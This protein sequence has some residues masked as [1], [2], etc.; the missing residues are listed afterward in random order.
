MKLQTVY[1]IITVAVLFFK[2][3]RKR[4]GKSLNSD[5]PRIITL[6]RTERKLTQKQ[7]AAALGI[8]QALLSHYE[9][10]IRECGLDFLVKAA[11]L[12]GVSCDYLLGRTPYRTGAQI[13]LD[14]IPDIDADAKDKLVRGG[15]MA[16]VLN[17]RL[18]V[19]SLNLLYDLLRKL[20]SKALTNEASAYLMLAV[21][22]VFHRL[23]VAN[24]KNAKSF[25]SVDKN[26]ADC[27]VNS[28]MQIAE[29]RMSSV[30]SGKDV[31]KLEGLESVEELELSEDYMQQT[32]PQYF[33]SLLGLIHAAE[34]RLPK[35]DE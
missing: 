30:A 28:A 14:D 10:G 11:D 4:G 23:Y 22:K 26:L 27:Y 33:G 15:S 12:Y 5:F 7:A 34:A 20:D 3:F 1:V 16:T 17:K 24:P 21:Y 2:I 6:L 19:N 9:R 29:A 13:T 25:F 35:D 8:S 32:Y 31:G 18:I